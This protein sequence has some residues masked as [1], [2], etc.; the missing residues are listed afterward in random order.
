MLCGRPERSADL[1]KGVFN[2]L[3]RFFDDFFCG[4]YGLFHGFCCFFFNLFD[5]FFY[6]FFALG[7]GNGSNGSAR[8]S[9]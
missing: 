9:T 5:F 4:F 3:L 2:R 8:F 7:R 1:F 6:G